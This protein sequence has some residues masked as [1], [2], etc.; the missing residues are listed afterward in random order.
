MFAERKRISLYVILLLGLLS[1]PAAAA[2]ESP[3]VL[4]GIAA[5]NAME[6]DKAIEALQ[7]GLRE[8]LTREEK[9][10]AYQTLAFC[11]VAVGKKADAIVDFEAVLRID[12]AF[13]LD[14][15]RSPLERAAFEEAKARVAMGQAEVREGALS[16]AALKP[17]ITPAQPHAGQ[18]VRLRVSYP[19]GMADKL[20]LFYRT[21]GLGLYS[22]LLVPGDSAGRFEAT[23]PGPRV[24]APG[25]EY[26]LIALDESGAS[27]ARAGSLAR[28][29]QLGVL[30]VRKPAYKRGWFWGLMSGL[31]LAGA[32]VA[33]AVVLTRPSVGPT[34]PASLTF[35]P[36]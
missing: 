3:E 30:E 36:Y 31:A 32:G 33:T 22:R 25:L 17:E 1:R 10:A 12:D 34:T 4:A 24:Q 26:Y 8:T 7:R 15:T 23:L 9:V 11:H 19:G 29:L 13:E 27:V 16:L 20:S 14:R 5:Y 28:P 21:R 35:M 6:Y 18:A 2:V